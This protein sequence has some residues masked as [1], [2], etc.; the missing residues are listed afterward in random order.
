MKAIFGEKAEDVRDT[1]L[2][3]PAGVEGMVVDVKILIRKTIRG[4]TKEEL[5]Q[6]RKEIDVIR[7]HAAKEISGLHNEVVGRIVKLVTS[8]PLWR[9][10]SDEAY[11]TRERFSLARSSSAFEQAILDIAGGGQTSTDASTVDSGYG[12]G[13]V[14]T[15]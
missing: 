9:R 3:V 12:E 6:E 15:V 2:R 7:K 14:R 11:K 13:E 10:M 5:Q 1:S 8:G 4:K